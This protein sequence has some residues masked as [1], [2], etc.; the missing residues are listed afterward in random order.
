MQQQRPKWAKRWNEKLNWK[1]QQ[2]GKWIKCAT[3]SFPYSSTLDSCAT[4]FDYCATTS[5]LYA[6]TSSTRRMF[7]VVSRLTLNG[8]WIVERRRDND[9]MSNTRQM[10]YVATRWCLCNEDALSRVKV[11]LLNFTVG[12]WSFNFPTQREY[13]YTTW[14]SEFEKVEL[15]HAKKR[16]PLVGL[17]IINWQT[18]CLK[19]ADSPLA[20]NDNQFIHSRLRIKLTN[21]RLS[22]LLH[23]EAADFFLHHI[24]SSISLQLV[25]TIVKF[26]IWSKERLFTTLCHSLQSSSRVY[27]AVLS[28]ERDS[29]GSI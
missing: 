13:M 20:T 14:Y 18:S 9:W 7:Y 29:R 16:E 1:T 25:T 11:Q 17:K 10:N 12:D 15:I 27:G 28:Q 6:R 24:L 2:G 5:S 26:G 21:Y 22:R 8:W 23:T 3:F 19:A 4:W